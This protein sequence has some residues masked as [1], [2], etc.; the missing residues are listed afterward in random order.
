[1]NLKTTSRTR[2]TRKFFII[3]ASI[4]IFSSTRVLTFCFCLI[5]GFAADTMHMARLYDTSR[6]PNEYSLSKLST[7]L[8]PSM[9]SV[10]NQYVKRI[11]ETADEATKARVRTYLQFNEGQLIKIDMKTLF[12]YKKILKSGEEGKTLVM[13]D[14]LEL[15]TTP[16]YINDW[17][18]YSVLDAEATYYLRDTLAEG[19]K[20]LSCNSKTHINP[21]PHLRNNYDLY[22]EFWRPFGELMTDMERNGFKINIEYLQ[23]NQKLRKYKQ[24][25]KRTSRNTRMRSSNG[26]ALFKRTCLSSIQDQYRKCNSCFLRLVIN[27]CY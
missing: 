10:R 26:L 15:H 22:M 19:L 18:G 17:I 5:R 20:T 6:M 13:P 7:H 4:V 21:L 1:M 2:S 25:H 9:L 14:I 3:S 8:H 23:V 12:Q 24:T 27:G 16:K 11:L